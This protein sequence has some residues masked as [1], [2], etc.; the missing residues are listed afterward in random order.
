MKGLELAEQYFVVVG[1]PMIRKQFPDYEVRIAAGLVGMGS[2]CFGFD[3]EISRDH[4]WGP[5]FCLWLNAADY[6]AIGTALQNAF[7]KMPASFGGFEPRRESVWG[8][9]RTGVFEI[10]QFY[11][12]FIGYDH[13]PQ[14]LDEWRVIPEI[15]LATAT[16][17]RVFTDPLGEFTAFRQRLLEFYPED[18]RLKK[19]ASRCMTLAQAGQYNYPRC[20]RRREYVAAQ[21]QETKFVSDLISLA[22]LLNSRYRPFPK[23]MHRALADLPRLGETLHELTERLVTL[24]EGLSGEALY[25]GKQHLMEEMCQFVIG[26]LRRQGLSDAASDFLLDHGPVVWNHIQD[27]QLRAGD[28]WAE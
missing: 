2:E 18:I 28:V 23:W 1:A 12:Q 7:T 14:N 19:I 15:N 16:N 8:R 21:W 13:P 26:E 5:T 9:G 4:D 6:A 24:H 17:G 22:F 10:G 20:I 11:K 27:P 3:D 25:E